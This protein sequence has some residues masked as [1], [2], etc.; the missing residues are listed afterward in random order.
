LFFVKTANRYCYEDKYNLPQ[1]QQKM[2]YKKDGRSHVLGTGIIDHK[3]LKKG[4]GKSFEWEGNLHKL[5]PYNTDR[6]SYILKETCE[7]LNIDYT[8]FVKI[9]KQI[10]KEINECKSSQ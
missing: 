5:M 2:V 8:N 1:I 3:V 7:V 4:N 9:L 6:V 10:E